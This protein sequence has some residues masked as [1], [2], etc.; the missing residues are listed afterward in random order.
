MDRKKDFQA[1][2]AAIRADTGKEFPKAMMNSRQEMN[3]T[4]TVNCGGSWGTPSS[5]GRMAENIM[6]DERFQAFLERQEG[7]A[8]A[9]KIGAAYPFYQIRI[10]FKRREN[11]E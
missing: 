11:H 2:I 10:T 6:A 4:A 7:T 9:E 1:V 8:E 3:G 5:T